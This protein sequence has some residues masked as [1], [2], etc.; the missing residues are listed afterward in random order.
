MSKNPSKTTIEREK[1]EAEL[2]LQNPTQYLLTRS[3]GSIRLAKKGLVN[4]GI[5]PLSAKVQTSKQKKSQAAWKKV[6]KIKKELTKFKIDHQSTTQR[7]TLKIGN[8]KKRIT[9]INFTFDF[10]QTKS[11][12][13]IQHY[14]KPTVKLIMAKLKRLKLNFKNKTI[15]QLYARTDFKDRKGNLE[16]RE[17]KFKLVLT[18]SYSALENQIN[19]LFQTFQDISTKYK[20][21]IQF[22]DLTIDYIG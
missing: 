1:R 18:N 7:R 12:V 17:G 2:Y 9:E 10:T 22:M 16:E 15:I 8:I 21:I 3:L 11:K 5:T 14:A 19:A 4:K 6:K 20:W 13:N